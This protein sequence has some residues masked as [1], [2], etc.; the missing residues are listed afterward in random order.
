VL[1]DSVVDLDVL[2][3][4]GTAAGDGWLPRFGSTQI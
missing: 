4:L 1:G 2:L 3:A